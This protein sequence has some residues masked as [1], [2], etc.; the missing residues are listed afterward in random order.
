MYCPQ[1]TKGLTMRVLMK[2]GLLALALLCNPSFAGIYTDELS[3]CLV[4]NSTEKDKSIL[5]R[6]MFTAMA[7]HP[8]I[9]AMAK[10][11]DE[12]RQQANKDVAQMITRFLAETCLN[13]SQKAVKYEGSSAIEQGFNLF[14]QVAGKELFTNPQ[15]AQAL[16]EL[17]Q[18]IDSDALNKKLGL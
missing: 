8:D 7:L 16:G 1:T 18:H 11:T 4:K 12:Q 13:Q 9:A 14:G 6:W 10:V 3:K 2:T 15:V 5:V 17:S